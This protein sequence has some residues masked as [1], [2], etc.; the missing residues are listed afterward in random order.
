MI[1]SRLE[2]GAQWMLVAAFLF[3]PAAMALGNI[4]MLLTGLLALLSGVLWR[5]RRTWRSAPYPWLMLGLYGVV[6]LGGL[7]SSAPWGDIQLNYTKYIK[8]LLGAVFFVLLAQPQW[9]TRCLQAFSACMLFILVSVYANIWLQLPWSK[10]QSLGW[11]V[12]HTVIGDYITQNIMMSFFVVLALWYCKNAPRLSLRLLA[13][14]V[15]LLAAVAITQLSQGRTGYVLVTLGVSSFVFFA[16]KGYQRWLALLTIVVAVSGAYAVSQTA[17]ERVHQAIT[18]ARNSESMEIT[19]I[20]GRINFWKHTWELV[21]QRPLTGWGT[22][23]YHDEWCRYVTEPGW[24]G[25]GSRHPHNQ[26]LL[27]WMENGLIG[28]LLF[29]G[30]LAATAHSVWRD[31]RWRPV[32]LSFLVIL[33]ANSLINVSL[34]SSRES[35]FFTMMLS[36]LAAQAYFGTRQT[37]AA[38]EK[39]RM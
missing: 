34:W 14:A 25:F 33:A 17:Q 29:I 27:F 8:L 23:S 26:Y 13:A 6:L 39:D 32:V 28:V 10:T 5:E 19:S 3:F 31:D 9:R 21:Q 15:A 35:H 18:E 22:G 11:G 38:L 30:I 2:T 36:L 4:A 16:L 12:D 24:C 20:G 1:T 37:S 7:W